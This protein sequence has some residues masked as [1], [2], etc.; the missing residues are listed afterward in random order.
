MNLGL[1]YEVN[2]QL[3]QKLIMGMELKSDMFENACVRT[4]ALLKQ[5]AY[6]KPLRLI[7]HRLDKYRG[8][9]DGLL[10]ISSP[11]WAKEIFDYYRNENRLLI[12][13]APWSMITVI[14]HALVGLLESLKALWESL[15]QDSWKLGYATVSLNRRIDLFMKP[16]L[17]LPPNRQPEEV[18]DVR[19]M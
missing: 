8:I 6:Q 16:K 3:R 11:A 1:R 4:E 15:E 10:G 19:S 7:K 5:K 17:P 9:I 13:Y 14:D 2:M 18:P 12:E